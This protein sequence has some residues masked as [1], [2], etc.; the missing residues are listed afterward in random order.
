MRLILIA[1]GLAAFIGTAA[2]QVTNQPPN[3]GDIVFSELEKRLLSDYFGAGKASTGGEKKTKKSKGKKTKAK[4]K[5]KGGRGGGPP[6][7]LAKKGSLP[8]GLAR[9]LERNG[10]LPPGLAKRDLPT[11][12][13]AKLPPTDAGHERVIV[14]NDVVL[15]EQATGRILDILENV[16]K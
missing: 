16:I 11:D 3:L 7:G 4:G 10:T 1:L 13:E 2:A 15:I 8:P 12:L 5:G 6:P 9:Q 14:D